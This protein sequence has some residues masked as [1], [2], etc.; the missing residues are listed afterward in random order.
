[1]VCANTFSKR[2]LLNLYA[3]SDAVLRPYQKIYNDSMLNLLIGYQR[4][5]CLR[6]L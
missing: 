1:M 4:A 6:F 3:H 2:A 5:Y